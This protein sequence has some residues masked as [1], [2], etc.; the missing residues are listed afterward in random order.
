MSVFNLN[1]YQVEREIKEALK[2]SIVYAEIEGQKIAVRD[3]RK[4]GA[5]NFELQV[6]VAEGWRTPERVWTQ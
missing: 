1:E 4:N 2:S 3:A 6:K 5:S